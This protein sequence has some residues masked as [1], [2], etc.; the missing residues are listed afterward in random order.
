MAEV[1]WLAE[2]SRAHKLR[3]ECESSL[4]KAIKGARKAGFPWQKIADA[5]GITQQGAR[6]HWKSLVEAK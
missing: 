4:L 3:N 6:Q 2:I 5:M 1:D